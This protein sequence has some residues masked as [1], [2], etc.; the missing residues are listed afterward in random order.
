MLS[1]I[2]LTAV[3]GGAFAFKA[4]NAFGG[5]LYCT[6]TSGATALATTYGPTVAPAGTSL[7]CTAAPSVVATSFTRVIT[8]AGN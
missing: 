7:Y 1:V 6:A 2:A 8:N 5:H 3:V 4:H